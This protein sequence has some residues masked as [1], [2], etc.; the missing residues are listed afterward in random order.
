MSKGK[1]KK[2]RRM[3]VPTPAPQT[4]EP[5]P[6]PPRKPEPAPKLESESNGA[7]S[8]KLESAP[9]FRLPDW[10]AFAAA[11]LVTL[12]VYLFTLAPNVT[13]E[14]SGELATA[15]MYAGVPHAPGYPFW[16][17]YSWA[18]TKLIPFG[19]IAWRVGMSSAVAAALACGL[20]ALMISRGSRLFFNSI[21]GL[22]N[23]DDNTQCSISRVAGFAGGTIFGLTGFMWSQAVIVEVYTLSTFTFAGVLALLMRW[24]F[25]P[26]RH[27]SL[28]AAYLVFGLCLANHQTLLLAAVGIE[29][30][31]FMRHREIGRDLF[32]CNSLIYLTGL[33]YFSSQESGSTTSGKLLLFGTFNLVGVGCILLAVWHSFPRPSGALRSSALLLGFA[34]MLVFLLLSI[35]WI[36]FIWPITLGPSAVAKSIIPNSTTIWHLSSVWLYGITTGH[37]IVLLFFF[38][39]AVAAILSLVWLAILADKRSKRSVYAGT[40]LAVFMVFGLVWMWFLLQSRGYVRHPDS[41]L[42][43]WPK[44]IADNVHIQLKAYFSKANKITLAFVLASIAGFTA[45]LSHN[46]I[47]TKSKALTHWKPLMTTRIAALA[48]LLFYFFL[49]LSSLTNPPMNWAYPRTAEG[50]DHAITR[51]QYTGPA[52][53]STDRVER[54]IIDVDGNK[55]VDGGQV[56]VFIS[57]TMQEFNPAYTLLA[58]LPFAFI[59]KMENRERRWLGGM[60]LIFTIL[61][62]LMLAFRNTGGSE[63]QRHLNKVFF[64]SSH[65]FVALGLGWGI[66]LVAGFAASNWNKYRQPLLIGASTLFALELFWWPITQTTISTTPTSLAFTLA[67][68]DAPILIAAAVIGV[69]LTGGVCIMLLAQRKAAPLKLMLLIF[70]LLPTRHGLANWWNN[71]MRGHYFGYWYGRDMFTTN[72]RDKEGALIYPPMARNAVL[73]G[74]TD[75]G[76]F[77]PTYMIFCESLTDSKQRTDSAFDRRDVNII[78]QNALADPTYLQYIRA[79][80]NRSA[81]LDPPFIHSLLTSSKADSKIS[82]IITN[83]HKIVAN[84]FTT[85]TELGMQQVSNLVAQIATTL[86]PG[87]FKNMTNSSIMPSD[88]IDTLINNIEDSRKREQVTK[89]NNELKTTESKLKILE[90]TANTELVRLNNIAVKTLNQRPFDGLNF[91]PRLFHPL[92]NWM[93]QMGNAVEYKHRVGNALF[94]EDDF[95]ELESLANELLESKTTIAT[96]LRNRLTKDTLSA[97]KKKG[98]ST[99]RFLAADLNTIIKADSD[100]QRKTAKFLLSLERKEMTLLRQGF[101]KNPKRPGQILDLINAIIN[102]QQQI[103]N[104]SQ[105]CRTDPQTPSPE[106]LKSELL[107]IDQDI[108]DHYGKTIPTHINLTAITKIIHKRK[109]AIASLCVPLLDTPGTFIDKQVSQKTSALRSQNPWTH[110]RTMLNR[111]LLEDVFSDLIRPASGGVYPSIEIQIPNDN[112][113][114]VSRDRVIR[115]PGLRE[116]SKV[117]EIN[118]DLSK[119][120]FDRNPNHEFYLEE[121]M[122]LPWMYPHLVPYGIIFKIERTPVG[123]WSE[124]QQKEIL[125]RDRAFWTQYMDRLIG[126]AIVEPNTPITDICSWIEQVH[127]RRNHANHT[128]VQKRFLRSYVSQRAFSKLRLSIAKLYDWRVRN[129]ENLPKDPVK[130]NAKAK[131]LGKQK[132]EL[133]SE[134]DFAFRQAYALCPVSAETVHE[135]LAFLLRNERTK[136]AHFILASSLNMDPS[137]DVLKNACLQ[138]LKTQGKNHFN[139][140]NLTS[141][142]S[143]IKTGQTFFPR[144]IGND[145]ILKDRMV[146][147]NALRKGEYRDAF[148]HISDLIPAKALHQRIDWNSLIS[149]AGMLTGHL[150]SKPDDRMLQ[151]LSAQVFRLLP[152]IAGRQFQQR[153]ITKDD[154][155][156]LKSR[157]LIAE[158]KLRRQLTEQTPNRPGAWYELGVTLNQLQQTN[159][160]IDC[161]KKAWELSGQTNTPRSIVDIRELIRTTN[162]LNNL[163]DLPEFKAIIQNP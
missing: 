67:N 155:I 57:E 41:P 119:L 35:F 22:R 40:W 9:F 124:N 62:L 121:S 140:G 45:I 77:C 100:K 149:Y 98:S 10:T 25:I 7:T 148:K 42:P 146:F 74:G 27:W 84:N 11:T 95:I 85:E 94:T 87:A 142:R 39:L 92:D 156:Q 63:Q 131:L 125:K 16:T 101:P 46:W 75:A 102:R 130:S 19:N 138:Q 61:T 1:R 21:G 160:T 2:S 44:E 50:F 113:Y 34:Y 122:T 33:L 114:S 60:A 111:Q 6:A 37:R 48:G 137:D 18:F 53:E 47:A 129:I 134:A 151:V 157:F 68:Y 54:F 65:L 81:Q 163:R 38:F 109:S 117:W 66:A 112:D 28:Y 5:N 110:A 90:A 55:K 135:Y 118:S 107:M 23:L 82:N 136:E 132:K 120:I 56:G 76:R 158:A 162:A 133:L 83:Y 86:G 8:F 143:I 96:Q 20:T 29:L 150:E 58:L 161:L 106:K 32:I 52:Q 72:V 154:Y 78:T 141:A 73:F 14:D 103:L 4:S 153:A 115:M 51:G 116:E 15:S 128:P 159:K 80:Y 123:Q 108:L 104:L 88:Y 127:I 144:F 71:E 31:I 36:T 64:E 69:L 145:P 59:F 91:W 49:P 79:H 24:Y 17:L 147:D 70:C 139:L 105:Y 89:F 30:L 13:L 3:S 126:G 43:P 26:D 97:L 93:T 12:A 152:V 99:A